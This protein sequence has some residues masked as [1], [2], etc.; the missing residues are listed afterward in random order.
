M[1]NRK[2]QMWVY[3][4]SRFSQYRDRWIAAADSTMAHLASY[5]SSRP[6]LTFLAAFQNKTL[7]YESGHLV[8][9]TLNITSYCPVS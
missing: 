5:P 2:L 4:P 3:D 6:D 9:S 1:A 8:S 7:D